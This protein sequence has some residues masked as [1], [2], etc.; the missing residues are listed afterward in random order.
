MQD[1]RLDFLV[2]GF[3]DGSLSEEDAEELDLRIRTEPAARRRFWELARMHGEL[4]LWGERRVAQGHA[5]RTLAHLPPEKTARILPR[6]RLWVSVSAAAAAVALAALV[7]GGRFSSQVVEPHAPV[8]ASREVLGLRVVES[9][10]VYVS[11]KGP[12]NAGELRAGD[13]ELQEGS[14]YF[15]LRNGVDLTLQGPARFTLHDL[16]RI[17][18]VQGAIRALVPE[19][20]RGFTIESS[21]ARFEDL[22]TEFGVEVDAQGRSAVSVFDGEVRVKTPDTNRPL[23]LV[24]FGQALEVKGRE[25]RPLQKPSSASFPSMDAVASRGWQAESRRLRQD[26]DLLAYYPFEADPADPHLL[27]DAALHGT[28]ADGTIQGAQWVTGR[29]SGKSALQFESPGDGVW[30]SLPGE[31]KDVSMAAW[32]RVD[33]LDHPLNAVLNTNGWSE[34]GFH[35]QINRI[36]SLSSSG[37][38]G[39][40]HGSIDQ[41]GRVPLGKWVHLALVWDSQAGELR[42]FLNGDVLCVRGWKHPGFRVSLEDACIGRLEKWEPGDHREFRG[43]IDEMAV[44]RRALSGAELKR[45][46]ELGS[47]TRPGQ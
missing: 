17:T 39:G 38:Y 23:A 3:L 14:A 22:G 35:W 36:G 15:R 5:A 40:R 18:L 7:F 31:H 27:R 47:P 16:S 25:L 21:E 10:A 29:W 20:A 26:P 13:Y 2:H 33:R 46:A 42:H 30:L 32:I 1:P 34:G 8:S 19:G 41:K 9:E 43:R 11:G 12:G 28:G 4:R 6:K 45:F 44:W 37:I 24:R